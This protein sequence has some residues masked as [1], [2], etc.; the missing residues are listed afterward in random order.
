MLL[1]YFKRTLRRNLKPFRFILWW[2]YVGAFFEN[3][4]MTENMRDVCFQ[5]KFHL[6]LRQN[7]TTLCSLLWQL[8]NFRDSP[9]SNP[10]IVS[11]HFKSSEK[12]NLEKPNLDLLGCLTRAQL[13]DL[14]SVHEQP[15]L[16]VILAVAHTFTARFASHEENQVDFAT[17]EGEEGFFCRASRRVGTPRTLSGPMW[18]SP[19]NRNRGTPTRR[20]SRWAP[21]SLASRRTTVPDI[22]SKSPRGASGCPRLW[23]S[24]Q[25]ENQHVRNSKPTKSVL[26]P[27]PCPWAL[28]LSKLWGCP[29]VELVT[30]TV[31]ALRSATRS[32]WPARPL[33]L[34]TLSLSLWLGLVLC[35]LLSLSDLCDQLGLSEQQ[36]APMAGCGSQTHENASWSEI[37]SQVW[38]W[39]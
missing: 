17:D 33:C 30:K 15:G 34:T 31:S 9:R 14:L 4:N 2:S 26:A 38:Q 12:P 20:T 37:F 23:L 10:Q 1:R 27:R 6:V 11:N 25:H 22:W 35:P 3:R 39:V 5:T 32:L 18:S 13:S 7:D 28:S 29:K 16:L 19:P 8:H 36:W 24:V 21:W